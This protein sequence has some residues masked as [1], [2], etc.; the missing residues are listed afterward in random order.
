MRRVLAA[1]MASFVQSEV[2]SAIGVGFV[3]VD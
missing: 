2:E 3:W 1:A